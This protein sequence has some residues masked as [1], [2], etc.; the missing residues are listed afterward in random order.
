V[1]L[2]GFYIVY[3]EAS[4]PQHPYVIPMLKILSSDIFACVVKQQH[5][6]ATKA[7]L[8]GSRIGWVASLY[9]SRVFMVDFLQR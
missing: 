4:A 5:C 7:S 1:D 8:Q 3:I 6:V 9:S 2:N